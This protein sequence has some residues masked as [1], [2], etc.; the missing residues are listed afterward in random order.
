MTNKTRAHSASANGVGI[1]TLLTL[2]FIGLKLSDHIDWSWWW[3]LSPMWLP[4]AAFPVLFIVVMV[5]S[6]I[7][8]LVMRR[9]R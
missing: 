6:V 5:G 2:L 9:L 4:L 1:G 8:G 7:V 3:V